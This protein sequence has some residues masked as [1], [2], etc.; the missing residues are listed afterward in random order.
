MTPGTIANDAVLVLDTELER[1]I[2]AAARVVGVAPAEFIARAIQRRCAEVLGE[3]Q[4]TAVSVDGSVLWAIR[5]T[6]SRVLRIVAQ[7]SGLPIESIAGPG[8]RP[9]TARARM[10]A[11]YLL[12]NDAGLSVQETAHILHRKAPAVARL[13][14][15]LERLTGS[16]DPRA[17][18]LQRARRLLRNGLSSGKQYPPLKPGTASTELLPGLLACR[19]AAGLTQP[20]LAARA[21]I[22]RETLVRLERLR[23][24]AQPET[25]ERLANA[26]GVQPACLT[27]A[28]LGLAAVPR[29]RRRGTLPVAGREINVQIA[30]RD[31]VGR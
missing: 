1:R 31:D 23:R 12:H 5:P 8:Q 3:Q 17:V 22:A 11:A 10:V 27:T 16:T 28:T 24:R 2:A 18:L 14:A 21:G 15:D 13:T 29:A 20:G 7:V 6:P 19:L 30:A 4:A 9:S 26:L 25:V